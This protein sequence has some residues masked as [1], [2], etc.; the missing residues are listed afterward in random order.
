MKLREIDDSLIDTDIDAELEK[1]LSESMERVNKISKEAKEKLHITNARKKL[2]VIAE[3]MSQETE[4]K[5]IKTVECYHTQLCANCANI[6]TQ[7][8]GT[9]QILQHRKYRDRRNLIKVPEQ[10][11]TIN[12]LY[13]IKTQEVVKACVKCR[14]TLIDITN[15][16]EYKSLFQ[17]LEI[18]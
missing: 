3:R 1:L 9:Y 17:G 5:L 11:K 18:K 8:S 2:E 10:F 7:Y 14:D 16:P 6:H 4:W 13:L 15:D 12:E